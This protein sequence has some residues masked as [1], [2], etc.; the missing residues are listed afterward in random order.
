MGSAY[1]KAEKKFISKE[2]VMEN[3]GLLPKEFDR[4]VVLCGVHPY[5]PKESRKVD[6]GDGFYYRISDANR[7]VHSDVY[8]VMQQHKKQRSRAERYT[9]TGLEYKVKNI[10]YEE[11]GYVELVR[12]RFAKF[13]E[14]VDGLSQSLNNMYLGRMLG[15][16][17]RLNEVIGEFEAFVARN[18]LLEH[19]FM[20]RNGVYHQASFEGIKVIWLVP[21]P[22][23]ELR[24]VV[25]EKQDMLPKFQWSELNFLDF[26]SSSEDSESDEMEEAVN[27]PDKMD[28]SLLLYSIP[29]LIIHC[30]LVIHKME[31]LY[32]DRTPTA[33]IFSGARL[34]IK[35]STVGDSLRLV[36][37]SCGGDVVGDAQNADIHVSETVDEL[38]DGVSYVQPQ[39]LLDCLNECSRIEIGP[40]LVGK[41]L[42]VHRLPFT[43]ASHVVRPENL[44]TMSKT[45]RDRVQDIVNQFED[46]EYE[47]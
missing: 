20:S 47:R 11:H 5:I 42:P 30:R 12:S 2:L 31:K 4:L 43:S 28:V 29:F 3:L 36:A 6:G 26:V 37:Q 25:E 17:E 14:S 22:G 9:G 32:A 16:D 23:A 8:R 19:S 34:H 24:D 15:L 18:A 21:H 13:G 44:M 45:Q 33:G 39:Y 10:C 7:L 38:V 35:S 41:M 40:Y 46:V 27:D 1:I